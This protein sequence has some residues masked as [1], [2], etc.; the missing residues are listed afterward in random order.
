MLDAAM[1]RAACE[2]AAAA[3]AATRAHLSPRAALRADL[4]GEVVEPPEGDAYG[5]DDS[6][7]ADF[8]ELQ[9]G[10]AAM[11]VDPQRRLQR[12]RSEVDGGTAEDSALPHPSR[13]V[14]ASPSSP[15][16]TPLSQSQ[17]QPTQPRP[18][19]PA[20]PATRAASLLPPPSDDER[21]TAAGAAQRLQRRARAAAAS[22]SCQ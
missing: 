2:R 14:A 16:A 4:E 7:L 5:C 17:P 3:A 21:Y 8:P 9:R 6:E 10:P 1:E 13:R 22:S 18:A 20:R 19:A 12:R 15:Q 11:A